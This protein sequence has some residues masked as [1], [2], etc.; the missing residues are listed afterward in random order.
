MLLLINSEDNSEIFVIGVGQGYTF[1][2]NYMK[3]C[4]AEE[5]MT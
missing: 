4:P 1:H 2:S 3:S 5:L